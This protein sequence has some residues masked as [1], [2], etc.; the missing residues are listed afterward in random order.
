MCFKCQRIEFKVEGAAQ[1]LSRFNIEGAAQHLSRL[2]V[3]SAAQHLSSLELMHQ[4]V[5]KLVVLF[6][7]HELFT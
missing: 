3:E 1:H 2:N 7:G 4:K 5:L 6:D